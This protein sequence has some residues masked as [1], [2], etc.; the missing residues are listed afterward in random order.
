D[1]R[2]EALIDAPVITD[3][4]QRA[5]LKLLTELWVPAHLVTPKLRT[6]MV[7]KQVNFS[8]S[9]GHTEVSAFGYMAYGSNLARAADRYA[10]AQAFGRLALALNE[11]FNNASLTANLHFM[12]GV[13]A[14]LFEPIQAAVVYLARAQQAGLATGDL[15]RAAYATAFIPPLRM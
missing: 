10:E 14:H 9:H 13:C 11:R 1:R 7:L 15:A 2:I 12:F 8:L 3:P 4:A 5:I 6:L